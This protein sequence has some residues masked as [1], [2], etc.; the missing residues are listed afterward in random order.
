MSVCTPKSFDL[1][2]KVALDHRRFLRHRLCHCHRYGQL[3]RQD[4][5]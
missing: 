5:L 3:R 4:R 2:G 1:T